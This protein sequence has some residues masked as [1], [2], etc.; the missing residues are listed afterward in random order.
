MIF[1]EI[2]VD[3]LGYSLVMCIKYYNYVVFFIY[4]VL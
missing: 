1:V 2:K 3:G 4:F